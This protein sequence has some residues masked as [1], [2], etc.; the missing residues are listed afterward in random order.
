MLETGSVG[1]ISTKRL[2]QEVPML[3]TAILVMSLILSVALGVA[4]A[5]SAAAFGLFVREM[6]HGVVVAAIGVIALFAE[7]LAIIGAFWFLW[8]HYYADRYPISQSIGITAFIVL[9]VLSVV[10]GWQRYKVLAK[11]TTGSS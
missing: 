11:R 3:D 6:I 2:F 8:L 10:W 1:K 4:L 7:T 9:V 5:G